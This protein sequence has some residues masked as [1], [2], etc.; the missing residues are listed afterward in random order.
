MARAMRLELPDRVPVMCQMSIGHMLLRTGLSP[1]EFWLSRDCFAEGLLSLR[2]QYE[3]DG[4]LVSLHGHSPDWEKNI[5]RVD[6]E[7]TGRP[8]PGRTAAGRFS[9]WTTCPQPERKPW[10]LRLR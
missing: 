5:V 1:V 3:F 2:R 10:P 4:I 8:S 7:K 6:H 9:R